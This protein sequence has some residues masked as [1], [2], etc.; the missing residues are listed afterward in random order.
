MK[1][2]SK[3]RLI[4]VVSIYCAIFLSLPLIYKSFAFNLFLLREFT[5]VSG[6]RKI[7]S[8]RLLRDDFPTR[9]NLINALVQDNSIG[10]YSRE[11]FYLAQENPNLVP[12]L[13][14]KYTDTPTDTQFKYLLLLMCL[15]KDRKN[16]ADFAEF[17]IRN[18]RIY[19]RNY[20]YSH[21]RT[22][23]SGTAAPPRFLNDRQQ[24]KE[25]MTAWKSQALKREK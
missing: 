7:A 16:F 13:E 11:L 6:V 5:Q 19:T 1:S 21:F 15:K 22:W 25:D 17:T 23:I 9:E 20:N 14:S 8:A 18:P 4:P 24:F 3:K 2:A 12:H 10:R